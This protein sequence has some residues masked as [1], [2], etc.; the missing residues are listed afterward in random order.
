M[1]RTGSIADFAFTRSMAGG[2]ALMTKT[3]KTA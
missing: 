1:I 2:A 3:T